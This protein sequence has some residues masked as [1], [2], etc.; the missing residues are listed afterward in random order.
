[1]RAKAV[2]TESE[3]SCLI[4]N[5]VTE[6]KTP[7]PCAAKDG[8]YIEGISY[9]G[10][11]IKVRVDTANGALCIDGMV[12]EEVDNIQRK[13]RLLCPNRLTVTAT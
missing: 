2:A 8:L 11:P 7:C 5:L 4:A 10:L 13:R 3:M 12:Q 1:M 9:D 6:I